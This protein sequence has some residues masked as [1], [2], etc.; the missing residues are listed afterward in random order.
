M[1]RLCQSVAQVFF[2]CFH[3]QCIFKTGKKDQRAAVLLVGT[4]LF[5][6]QDSRAYGF[7]CSYTE[8]WMTGVEAY[9]VSNVS[10]HGLL[11]RYSS[12]AR[13]LQPGGCVA[14]QS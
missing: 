7:D 1:L 10:L 14:G 4:W 9:H 3:P 2:V 5:T 8:F 11:S 6:G 12:V 13:S